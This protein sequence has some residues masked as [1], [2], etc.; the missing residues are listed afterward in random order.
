MLLPGRVCAGERSRRTVDDGADRMAAPRCLYE[1]EDGC[2]GVRALEARCRPPV[3]CDPPARV[4]DESTGSGARDLEA[5]MNP[6]V[7]P[8]ERD[9]HAAALRTLAE[10]GVPTLV[11]GAWAMFH[12]TSW[13]R[14]T[15][16]LDLFLRREDEAA[17][18][19]VLARAG[20]HTRVA[21][22]A[23]LS[24]ALRGPTLVDLIHCSGN[25]LAPVTDDWFRHAVPASVL[26]V[27]VRVVAPEEMIWS[28]AFVQERDRFDGADIAHL[29]R[30]GGGRLDWD[31]LVGRFGER[32]FQVLLA[33]LLLFS[34]SYPHDRDVVP[35]RVWR[36]LLAH[37]RRSSVEP[38]SGPKV[39]RGTFLSRTQYLPDLGLWGYRDARAL[40]VPGFAESEASSPLPPPVSFA[41]VAEGA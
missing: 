25:G 19:E 37:A 27:P 26:G 4:E 22:A 13:V 16:D 6:F 8:A 39:C 18:R 5:G 29:V 9:A 31:R 28:K 30:A 15:K 40:E 17:A 38:C 32:H 35:P 34:F 20:W 10:A 21:D 11:G 41:A 23:W 1:V 36:H 12:H 3:A 7:S 24:K 33:H 2:K 14:Y